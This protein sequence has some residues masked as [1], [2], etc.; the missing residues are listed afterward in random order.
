MLE[1]HIAMEEVERVYTDPD[2]VW[3]VPEHIDAKRTVTDFLAWI[4]CFDD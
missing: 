2:D 4:A 1:N 3:A